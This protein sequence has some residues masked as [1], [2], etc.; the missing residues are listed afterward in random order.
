MNGRRL[1]AAPPCSSSLEPGT[2]PRPRLSTQRQYL[3]CG[4]ALPDLETRL[5]ARFRQTVPQLLRTFQNTGKPF[6]TPVT[7]VR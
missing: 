2:G 7:L 5:P 6:C 4:R 3:G 1:Q